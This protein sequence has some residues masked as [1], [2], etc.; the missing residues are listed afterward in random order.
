MLVQGRS[1]S[2]STKGELINS[3]NQIRDSG[4]TARQD[5]KGSSL[6]QHTDISTNIRDAKKIIH[7]SR[8]TTETTAGTLDT[9]SEPE[10]YST[11][12]D[13]EG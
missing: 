13:W 2:T 11:F 9:K 1:R 12:P 8:T 7:N 5:R 10:C 3:D 6:A 4:C